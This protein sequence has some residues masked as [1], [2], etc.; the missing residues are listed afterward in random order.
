MNL[1]RVTQQTSGPGDS[2]PNQNV[3]LKPPLSAHTDEKGFRGRQLH[4]LKIG[5]CRSQTPDS[6]LFGVVSV[7]GATATKAA[8]GG[9]HKLGAFAAA[10]TCAVPTA[11]TVTTWVE[12]CFCGSS[13]AERD[14]AAPLDESCWRGKGM[15]T[16]LQA[17]ASSPT[18]THLMVRSM[19]ARDR[20]HACRREHTIIFKLSSVFVYIHARRSF[21]NEQ[22]LGRSLL[23]I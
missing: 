19:W 14:L 4:A 7:A 8:A 12:Q 9:E 6:P 10:V 1:K 23:T 17:P 18:S 2:F 13:S 11:T 16:S 21:K 20:S 15:W 3:E 22:M 5:R